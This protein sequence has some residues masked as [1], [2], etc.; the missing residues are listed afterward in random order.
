MKQIVVLSKAEMIAAFPVTIDMSKHHCISR[1]IDNSRPC[2][3]W[4]GSMLRRIRNCRFIII[5]IIIIKWFS[6]WETVNRLPQQL[7]VGYCLCL[8]KWYWNEKR[9]CWIWAF[10]FW[11]GVAHTLAAVSWG[12]RWSVANSY[13]LPA[14]NRDNLHVATGAHVNRVTFSY[15]LSLI[16]LYIQVKF[17]FNYLYFL[18]VERRMS[19]SRYL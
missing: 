6:I 15:T 13:L 5:T 18:V 17:K 3:G 14:M 9:A 19:S 7:S 2:N 10:L 12:R 16:A 8:F 4:W 11:E 1:H